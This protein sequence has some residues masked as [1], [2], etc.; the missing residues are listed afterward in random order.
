MKRLLDDISKP[1][2]LKAYPKAG[3]RMPLTIY[4]LS[5]TMIIFLIG[6]ALSVLIFIL[7]LKTSTKA[8]IHKQIK[9]CG[10]NS[11]EETSCNLPASLPVKAF[12]G[13]RVGAI[14]VNHK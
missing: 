13:Q 14:V 6:A 1:L 5:I 12:D 4:Q 10:K 11:D 2:V 9:K 8:G 3:P 7:E